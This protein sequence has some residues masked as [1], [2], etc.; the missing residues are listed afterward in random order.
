ML[1]NNPTPPTKDCGTPYDRETLSRLESELPAWDVTAYLPEET[2]Q[3]CTNTLSDIGFNPYDAKVES[4]LNREEPF[5][6]VYLQLRH[7]AADYIVRGTQ[8]SLGLLPH[9][10]GNWDW[11]VS[12][13]RLY[14]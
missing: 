12:T 14:F 6:Q 10:T 1:Y 3:W 8:P 5:K 2:L 11:Q 7:L 4:F 13:V 9:P